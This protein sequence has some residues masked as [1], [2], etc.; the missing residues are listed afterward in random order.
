MTSGHDRLLAQIEQIGNAIE[1]GGKFLNACFSAW[2]AGEPEHRV[3]T[4]LDLAEQFRGALEAL[5]IDR[6]P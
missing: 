6:Q 5:P 4:M 3:K 2:A 1:I